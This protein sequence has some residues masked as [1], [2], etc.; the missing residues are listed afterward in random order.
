MMMS[1]YREQFRWNYNRIMRE[2]DWT[3]D[4]PLTATACASNP[5]MMPQFPLSS[6]GYSN[7]VHCATECSSSSGGT[8]AAYFAALKTIRDATETAKAAASVG[9]N[10][11]NYT[12]E[13]SSTEFSHNRRYLGVPSVTT[14]DCTSEFSSLDPSS[15][16]HVDFKLLHASQP[17][18]SK[19]VNQPPSKERPSS[20]GLFHRSASFTFSPT[21]ESDRINAKQE[22]E[23][24]RRFPFSKQFTAVMHDLAVETTAVGF[25]DRITKTISFL[26]SKM[27]AASTSTLY[28][29]KEQVRQWEQSFESL[30][31]HKYGC[32]LFRTFLKGEFSDE[33]VDFWLECEEFKKMKEGKKSTIQK[34]H[35][36]FNEYVVEMAP[37]EVN[38]DSDTRAA[39]KAAL[40]KGARSDMFTLAQGRI[41]QLMAKD[42]YQRFLKSKLF[43]DL[44]NGDSTSGCS[45]RGAVKAS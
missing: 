32:L 3:H 33:N 7:N 26:R 34:A 41:E 20:T 45:N 6:K 25:S 39:T 19:S 24:K 23:L 44:L 8:T 29:S 36:I 35:A 30:L 28:P 18:V 13:S 43:L 31:S 5:Y 1:E 12:T 10:E 14:S 11:F 15:S 9:R 27:D 2:S 4:Q 38:L 22:T 16:N 42:S 21:R 40:E 17:I 37:K